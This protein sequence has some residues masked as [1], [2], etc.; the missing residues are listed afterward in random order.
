MH[1]SK[2]ILRKDQGCH[3]RGEQ[4][5][6]HLQVQLTQQHP[7]WWLPCRTKKLFLTQLW[8]VGPNL[9]LKVSNLRLK[10]RAWWLWLGSWKV[11]VRQE[12][13]ARH[14]IS[15]AKETSVELLNIKQVVEMGVISQDVKNKVLELLGNEIRGLSVAIFCTVQSSSFNINIK[16]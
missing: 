5:M 3:W 1:G 14:R 6:Y 12:T 2:S 7:L 13:M 10:Q 9:R 4:V 8:V 15:C 11:L 16:I